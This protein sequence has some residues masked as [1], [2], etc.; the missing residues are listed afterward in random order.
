VFVFEIKLIKVTNSKYRT[1]TV[2]SKNNLYCSVHT[3]WGQHALGLQCLT[4]F[5]IKTSLMHKRVKQ[6][7][8][9]I[10]RTS[11]STKITMLTKQKIKPETS[12]SNYKCTN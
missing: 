5:L 8:Q 2:K 10:V 3:G 12:Y 4:I 11:S 1:G 6:M 9:C 7:S